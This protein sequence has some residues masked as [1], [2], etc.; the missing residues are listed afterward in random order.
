MMDVH[1]IGEDF[2][3]SAYIEPEQPDYNY[4]LILFIAVVIAA[5]STIVLCAN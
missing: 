4:F 5:V 1:D 3:S 2:P